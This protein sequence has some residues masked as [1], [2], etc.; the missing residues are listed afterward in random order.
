VKVLPFRRP[1]LIKPSENAV[2]EMERQ[3]MVGWLFSPRP[4]FGA[5]K[6]DEIAEIQRQTDDPLRGD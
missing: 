2:A 4:F 5:S 3:M 6:V 1:L